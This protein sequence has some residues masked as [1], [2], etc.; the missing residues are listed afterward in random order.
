MNER[1][2]KQSD[3]CAFATYLA[4]EE[5]SKATVQK[6]VRDVRRF[7]V[8]MTDQPIDRT[9]ILS[10]KE[11]LAKEYAI[12]SANS[13]LAALNAFWKYKG[14][15][16]LCVKQ[17]K[18]QHRVFRSEILELT[19]DEYIHLVV[20]AYSQGNERLALLLQTVCGTGI[21]VSELKY[22]TVE[23]AYYGETTVSCKGKI[24]KVF[25]V[26]ALRRKL[27]QYAEKHKITTGQIFITKTGKAIDRSN[28]WRD[29]KALCEQTGI[30]SE[31][32]FPHNLRHV[33]A[34]EF[35]EL[36]KDIAKLA[37]ILGHSSL[38]T[39]R[40]YI[41]ETGSEHKK[42]MEAMQLIT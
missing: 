24:R 15:P 31:K 32:V 9:G 8:F 42:K 39:T 19:K 2:I 37:D 22:I 1:I 5:K 25:I 36:E 29:M 30:P 12:S 33:F 20:T 18:M 14:W 3:I 28:I 40:L 10:Y 27:L 23:A 17:F 38:N 35:Y 7:A 11:H 26:A 16:E 6:Y 13:M 34:R 21:R 4:A 41:M